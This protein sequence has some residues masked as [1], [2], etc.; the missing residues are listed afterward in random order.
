VLRS[1]D[2]GRKDGSWSIISGETSF[3]HTT[4]MSRKRRKKRREEKEEEALVCDV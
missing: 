4:V 1:S 2:D 3:T